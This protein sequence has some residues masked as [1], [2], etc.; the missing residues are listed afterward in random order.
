MTIRALPPVEYL[1][2][3]MHYDPQTGKLFWK[4]CDKMPNWWNGR[5]AFKEAMTAKCGNGYLTGAVDGVVYMAHRVAWAIQ[6]GTHPDGEIDH[7]NHIRHDNKFGNLRI[8]SGSDNCMNR[9]KAT[10]NTSGVTGVTW[11]A[12]KAK[13]V[14]YIKK[15]GASKKLGTFSSFSAAVA[16]RKEAEKMYGFHVNHGSEKPLAL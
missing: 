6:T 5:F 12:G 13:W 3:R 10:N 4:Q 9:T 7:I 1:R 2:Q 8:V 16:A 11:E 14:A 15:K